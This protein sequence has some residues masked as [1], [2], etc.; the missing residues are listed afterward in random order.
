MPVSCEGGR[1]AWVMRWRVSNEGEHALRILT[2]LQPH[3][4][5][6]NPERPVDLDLGVGAADQVVLPVSFDE[7]AGAVV[8][9]A[10]LILRVSATE[11][12]WRVLA[13]LRV[14]ADERGQPRVDVQA[15]TTQR[16]GFANT[17]AT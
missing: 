11:R 15:I 3:G 17:N 7:P 12:D 4:R 13:R 9:N 10:F 8:E 14:A 2:A 6:K 5:F 16:V 1:P